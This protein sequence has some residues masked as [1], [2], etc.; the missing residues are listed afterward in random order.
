MSWERYYLWETAPHFGAR[1]VGRTDGYP[2]VEALQGPIGEEISI[3]L[4]RESGCPC[5][6]A[7]ATVHEVLVEAEEGEVE[8]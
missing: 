8:A 6:I 1:Q 4:N 3:R 7:K 2:T 5:W